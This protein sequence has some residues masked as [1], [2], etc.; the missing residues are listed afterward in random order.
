MFN[1]DSV[2]KSH[3]NLIVL[4]SKLDTS[5]KLNLIYPDLLESIIVLAE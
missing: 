5:V 4:P 3:E 1:G 2:F